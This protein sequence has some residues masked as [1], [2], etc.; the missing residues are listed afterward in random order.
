MLTNRQDLAIRTVALQCLAL[1]PLALLVAGCTAASGKI[2]IRQLPSSENH[3]RVVR[4]RVPLR[5]AF[6]IEFDLELGD[7][8][9]STKLRAVI[10]FQFPDQVHLRAWQLAQPVFDLTITEGV[11]WWWSRSRR[12]RPRSFLILPLQERNAV[13]AVRS[14]AFLV[15]FPYV[16]D[17]PTFVEGDHKD[18]LA[19][20][21]LSQPGTRTYE[22]LVLD[23]G[24]MVIEER[25]I[26]RAGGKPRYT[27]S[28]AGHGVPDTK[29]LWPET[30][31][32]QGPHG[33]MNL[34]IRDVVLNADLPESAFN[35]P[36]RARRLRL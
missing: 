30:V 13:S 11:V 18:R 16:P 24:R 3:L 26:V 9:S 20:R 8:R 5:G 23:L 14:L 34:R 32:A 35:P 29:S 15:G 19:I 17:A 25:Q 10:A 7:Y 4:Q 27:I 12:L 21:V 6:S 1:V 33:Q 36:S 2:P 22:R 31:K 28:Y